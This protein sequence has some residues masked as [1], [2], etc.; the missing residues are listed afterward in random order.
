MRSKVTSAIA[1]ATACAAV[2]CAP[3]VHVRSAELTRP[4]QVRVSGATSVMNEEVSSRSLPPFGHGAEESARRGSLSWDALELTAGVGVFD[5]MEIDIFGGMS[6]QAAELRVA[7]LEQW[8]GDP[9]SL[10]VGFAGGHAFRW[11]PSTIQFGHDANGP[12]PFARVAID[13]SVRPVPWLLLVANYALGVE[14]WTSS[15][16]VYVSGDELRVL[17][18]AGIGIAPPSSDGSGARLILGFSV[19]GGLLALSRRTV[20]I[21]CCT[22]V[23]ASTPIA[24]TPGLA[25]ALSLGVEGVISTQ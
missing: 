11:I 20:G 1:L 12:A 4:G 19:E 9:F 14:P 16:G 18:G 2:G 24:A 25:F 3:L 7:V 22:G 15:N 13:W 10:A 8:R 21:S 5:R 17:A 23:A 6:R